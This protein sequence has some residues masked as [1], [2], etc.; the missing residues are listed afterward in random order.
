[1]DLVLMGWYICKLF[2]INSYLSAICGIMKCCP[3]LWSINDTT[4]SHRERKQG[5][6][7]TDL[8]FSTYLVSYHRDKML[9]GRWVHTGSPPD[10]LPAHGVQLVCTNEKKMALLIYQNLFDFFTN[11][12][13]RSLCG[14]M[15]NP[16]CGT[17]IKINTQYGR[18]VFL[19]NKCKR[20]LG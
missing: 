13:M 17:K 12:F 18:F 11:V 5:K 16:W 2:V 7:N 3:F 8:L 4:G 10:A 20:T 14:K 19:V 15:R 1:M 9:N 6:M